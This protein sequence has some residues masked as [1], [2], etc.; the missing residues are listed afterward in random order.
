M[1]G[2]LGGAWGSVLCCSL[3]SCTVARVRL[4]CGVGFGG[5]A[6]VAAKILASF[7]MS[8]MVWAPKQE[9]GA[10]VAGFSRASDRRLDASVAASAEDIA[11]MAPLWGENWTV[12]VMRSPCVSLI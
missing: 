6:T 7:R 1:G 11:G 3:D 2:T 12:L 9:K 8:Y 4:G 10:A 5:C